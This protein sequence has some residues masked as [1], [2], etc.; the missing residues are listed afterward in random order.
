MQRDT[1]RESSPTLEQADITLDA[2]LVTLAVRVHGLCQTARASLST[3]EATKSDTAPCS[4][5]VYH[6][7]VLA[8]VLSTA[9]CAV[10]TS[11]LIDEKS[12]ALKISQKNM[13][14]C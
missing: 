10:I 3:G 12:I 14:C 6:H 2:D 13:I 11:I 5:P 1:L 4:L 8:A 7:P 9:G